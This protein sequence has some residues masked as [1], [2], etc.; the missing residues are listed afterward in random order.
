MYEYTYTHACDYVFVYVFLDCSIYMH[1]YTYIRCMIS[2]YDVQKSEEMPTDLIKNT[3]ELS[4]DKMTAITFKQ[5]G[6]IQ[7]TK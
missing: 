3:R 6:G 2:G 4:S 1:A 7:R 5:F